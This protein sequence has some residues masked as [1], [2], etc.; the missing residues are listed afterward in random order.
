[1]LRLKLYIQRPFVDLSCFRCH[2]ESD[3]APFLR[4]V[5]PSIRLTWNSTLISFT[6]TSIGIMCGL[7]SAAKLQSNESVN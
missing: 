3:F 2:Y 7:K 6:R 4:S 5:C 1:M